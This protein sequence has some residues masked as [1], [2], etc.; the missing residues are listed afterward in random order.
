[1]SR[2][3][4]KRIVLAS[5][6]LGFFE[7]ARNH[8]DLIHNDTWSMGRLDADLGRLWTIR[9][10][11][12]DDYP[13]TRAV[14]DLCAGTDADVLELCLLPHLDDQLLLACVASHIDKPIAVTLMD[15]GSGCR[16]AFKE[17]PGRGPYLTD[18]ERERCVTLWQAATAPTPDALVSWL[19]APH[20]GELPIWAAVKSRLERFPDRRSGL[21]RWQRLVLDAVRVHTPKS[22]R[23]I[24]EIISNHYGELDS[25]GDGHLFDMLLALDQVSCP[26]PLVQST[27]D[28]AAI[29]STTMEITAFGRKVLAGEANH[30]VANGVDQ[31]VGGVHLDSA[32]GYVW[33]R[34]AL[35][36]TRVAVSEL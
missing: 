33:V 15:Q 7:Y 36:V 34:D 10:A 6:G 24:A 16:P 5:G 11:W 9:N 17:P 1:M 32:S 3:T 29:R 25:P 19:T 4:S 23:I 2:S 28:R 26:H 13:I 12:T 22:A 30:I 18:A 14:Y 27:G 35:A 31:W 21:N 8:A 20:V